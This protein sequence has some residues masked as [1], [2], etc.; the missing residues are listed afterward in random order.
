MMMALNFAK[1]DV[2]I[3]FHC[4]SVTTLD[5]NFRDVAWVC[6]SPTKVLTKSKSS[7]MTDEANAVMA[8]RDNHFMANVGK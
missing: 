1:S 4:A 2:V 8:A 3:V 7:A 6:S 5:V